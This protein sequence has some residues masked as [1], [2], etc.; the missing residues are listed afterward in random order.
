ME[1]INVMH[2]KAKKLPLNII[3]YKAFLSSA[4]A[5]LGST[6]VGEGLQKC[7]HDKKNQK[8]HCHFELNTFYFV[9]MTAHMSH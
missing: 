2:V 5:V 9:A 8:N 1:Q 7:F 6:E 3:C 4:N